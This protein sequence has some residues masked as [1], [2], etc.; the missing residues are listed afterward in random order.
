M[1]DQVGEQPRRTIDHEEIREWVASRGG[2]PARRRGMGAARAFAVTIDFGGH[3]ASEREPISWDE[4]FDHMDRNGLAFSY[5]PA[6]AEVEERRRVGRL[7]LDQQR[8]AAVRQ[9]HGARGPLPVPDRHPG[10]PALGPHLEVPVARD[11]R[12]QRGPG[13]QRN[14]AITSL[15]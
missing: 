13:H 1:D 7:P 2:R 9:L 8:V 5:R 6:G 10:R 11:Q 14:R 4:F 12:R 15:P 3:S